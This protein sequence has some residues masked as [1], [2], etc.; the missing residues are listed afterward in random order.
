L[1]ALVGLAMVGCGDKGAASDAGAANP[2]TTASTSE[3][4]D[5]AT[6]L[7]EQL[8][9]GS[10]QADVAMGS[11]EVAM[12]RVRPLA[13]Q[14]AEETREALQNIADMLD[15]AGATLSEFTD[16]P[17]LEEIRANFKEN[18]DRRLKAIEEA[19]DARKEVEQ[20]K[21]IVADMLLSEPPADV[22]ATLDEIDT[23]IDEAL[24][25]I[26]AAIEA[27]GGTIPDGGE[28]PE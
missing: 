8:R 16:A 24:D 23:A 17:T 25:A 14:N 26:E 6:A 4:K 3:P 21:G 13:A 20:A 5:E 19:D 18:D 9:G 27:F 10:Y 7:L 1:A 12:N 11:M 22:K 2:G 28:A 15:S